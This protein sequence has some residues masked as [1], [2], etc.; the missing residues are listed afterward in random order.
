MNSAN[1]FQVWDLP[2]RLCHW[3]MAVLVPVLWWTAENHQL[4]YHR[5]AGYTLMGVLAFRVYWGFF[6]SHTARFTQ[7]VRSPAAA[8][9]YAKQMIKGNEPAVTGHNPLGGYSVLLL[10]GLLVTQVVT[11]LFAIDVD[12]F[13][14]GPLADYID[15]DLSRTLAELHELFF[16]LVVAAIALH[17]LAILLHRIKGHNLV[18][19]MIH[20]KTQAA[21]QAATQA[22]TAFPV[23]AYLQTRFAVGVILAGMLVWAVISASP[24]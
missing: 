22:I 16:N 12:G 9:S 14:G 3:S 21:T 2:L 11:G 19:A 5:Y 24:Y 7:F 20:G 8:L 17:L 4:T 10:L 18:P 15:Y 1:S 23:Y 6:G 13:D